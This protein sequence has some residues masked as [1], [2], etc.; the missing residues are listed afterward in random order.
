MCFVLFSSFFFLCDDCAEMIACLFSCTFDVDPLS[1][2]QN[3]VSFFCFEAFFTPVFTLVLFAVHRK[4]ML[5]LEIT[6]ENQTKH[7]KTSVSFT[8]NL[9][10]FI[11]VQLMFYFKVP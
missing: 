8:I 3:R 6:E 1:C 10:A 7:N 11:K 9:K 4:G 5:Q 2:V